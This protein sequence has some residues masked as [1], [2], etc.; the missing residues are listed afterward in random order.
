MDHVENDMDDLFQKAGE[1]YPLNTDKS[2]WD[3]MLAKLDSGNIDNEA[4]T[5]IDEKVIQSKRK[6]RWLLLLL[7]L[8]LISYLFFKGHLEHRGSNQQLI[9]QKSTNDLAKSAPI[10]ENIKEPSDN[11]QLH[12]NK[13]P[14]EKTVSVFNEH[15]KKNES[16][17][18]GY[19]RLMSNRAADQKSDQVSNQTV[20]YP[21]EKWKPLSLTP[22]EFNARPRVVGKLLRGSSA[23]INMTAGL[24]NPKD[25]KIKKEKHINQGLYIGIVAGPDLSNVDFQ[26]VSKMGFGLGFIAGYR[27]SKHL[28]FET[29]LYWDKKFYYSDGS[30]FKPTKGVPSY[31]NISQVKGNCNMFELPIAVRYD[32]AVKKDHGFFAKAGLSSYFMQK[33]NYNIEGYVSQ[34]GSP[35]QYFNGDTTYARSPSSIFSIVQLSVGYEKSIGK[36]T[37]IR[38]EPYIKIPT[39]G[40]GYGNLPISSAGLLL[41]FSYSFR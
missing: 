19:T 9:S 21:E 18:Q 3:G 41:G 1:L 24:N 28:S 35:N 7:P 15:H 26:Q 37:K 30:Y 12:L 6:R 29:G 5:L 22:A 36:N 33:E 31:V 32:F 34:P 14:E 13:T 4:V 11:Q 2:D 8:A 16:M 40:I 17:L 39:Q 27:F 25:T 10:K 20:F 23:D 38:I